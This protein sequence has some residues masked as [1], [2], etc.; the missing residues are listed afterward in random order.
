MIFYNNEDKQT[1]NIF[2]TST[3][4][5]ARVPC[6]ML[7]HTYRMAITWQNA[8]YNQP[9]HLGYY[10]PDATQPRFTYSP[11]SLTE[12]EITLGDSLSPV[13]FH[14]NNCTGATLSKVIRP[15]E[16]TEDASSPAY[17][18]EKDARLCQMTL[19]GK[20]SAAG[21]WQFILS[22]TGS[23]NGMVASDTIRVKVVDPLGIESITAEDTGIGMEEDNTLYDLLGR[24]VIRPARPGVYIKGKK[25]III[26]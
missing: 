13:T 2:S 16:T 10:L 9:P 23:S 15:D 3:P 21:T 20:P 14:Y 4:S 25:K 22:S 24:K 26:R 6:L 12:Q 19:T 5:G 8:G 1:L 18:L 17:K 7:D 11:E